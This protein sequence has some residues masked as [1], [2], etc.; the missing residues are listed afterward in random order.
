MIRSPDAKS[1]MNP[2]EKETP[3]SA[4]SVHIRVLMLHRNVK[5][6][7][8]AKGLH[9]SH[10]LVSQTITGRKRNRRVRAAISSHLGVAQETLWPSKT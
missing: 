6:G 9:V 7:K 5:V 1:S 3:P 8:I 10:S 4:A 2:Q